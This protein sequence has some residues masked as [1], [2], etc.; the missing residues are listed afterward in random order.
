MNYEEEPKY[1]IFIGKLK[2]ILKRDHGLKSTH[3]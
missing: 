2:R 3:L 1:E